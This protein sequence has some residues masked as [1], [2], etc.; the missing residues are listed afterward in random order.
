MIM[1]VDETG[2]MRAG[3]HLGRLRRPIFAAGVLSAIAN[4][5]PERITSQL[6]AFPEWVSFY[7]RI[8][9]QL[10]DLAVGPPLA[11]ASED[12]PLLPQVDRFASNRAEIQVIHQFKEDEMGAIDALLTAIPERMRRHPDFEIFE[13]EEIV[14]SWVSRAGHQV[15]SCLPS[16]GARPEG[17]YL[18]HMANDARQRAHVH[19]V[20]RD[21]GSFAPGTGARFLMGMFGARRSTIRTAHGFH[22]IPR[23]ALVSIHFPQTESGPTAH[24]FWN[25]D[26]TP[27]VGNVLFSFHRHDVTQDAP[28]V[29]GSAMMGKRT[30]HLA[31]A[32]LARA[33]GHGFVLSPDE[34]AGNP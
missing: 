29:E 5:I 30:Y 32:A 6:A 3:P 1:H 13:G 19:G 9:E 7:E 2:P 25:E 8:L 14:A 10:F 17:G 22:R 34:E 26:E 11:L 20:R 23:G 18:M 21:D 31:R 33:P 12:A 16:I 4:T 28:A 24:Q 27:G 15:P